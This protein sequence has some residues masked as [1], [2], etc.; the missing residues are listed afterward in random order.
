MFEL[1]ASMVQAARRELSVEVVVNAESEIAD[2]LLRA[3]L[4]GQA[5]VVKEDLAGHEIHAYVSS[6]GSFIDAEEKH[7]AKFTLTEMVVR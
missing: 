6:G 1:T 3:A 5:V 4:A 7:W 2:A